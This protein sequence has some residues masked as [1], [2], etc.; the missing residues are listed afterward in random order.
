MGS[1][2]YR[3][4]RSSADTYVSC[5]T[6]GVA[7]CLRVGLGELHGVDIGYANVLF[8]AQVD[9]I[10]LDASRNLDVHSHVDARKRI[11]AAGISFRWHNSAR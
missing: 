2:E 1:S 9:N 11:E 5:Q 4:A 10:G 7:S 6:S 3:I 8:S